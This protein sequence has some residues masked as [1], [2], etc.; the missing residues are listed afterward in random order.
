MGIYNINN[1]D[2]IV[3]DVSYLRKELS[4][5]YLINLI[6]KDDGALIELIYNYDRYLLNVIKIKKHSLEQIQSIKSSK[7]IYEK[8]IKISIVSVKMNFLKYF[9]IKMVI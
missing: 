3:C 4:N 6:Q 8:I 7:N 9:H 2:V 1:N 5:Y